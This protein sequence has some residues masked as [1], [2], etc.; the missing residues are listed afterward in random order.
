MVRETY[1]SDS[2][3]QEKLNQLAEDIQ[4]KYNINVW[5][6][7]ILGKRLSYFAGETEI[8]LLP[9]KHKKLNEKFGIVSSEWG[10]LG[11]KQM[12]CIVKLA[13]SILES[14]EKK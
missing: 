1:S 3:L 8:K 10:K 6:V 11:E 9:A 4:K 7:K 14:Y 13:K 5:F 12:E 2:D